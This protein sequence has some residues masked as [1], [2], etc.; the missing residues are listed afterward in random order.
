MVAFMNSFLAQRY[1][2][3]QEAIHKNLKA[4]GVSKETMDRIEHISRPV[5]YGPD[6]QNPEHVEVHRVLVLEA[7]SELAKKNKTSSAKASS[8][9]ASSAKKK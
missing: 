5:G 3:A 6:P 9:K 1:D 7:L 8:A 4:A 2:E